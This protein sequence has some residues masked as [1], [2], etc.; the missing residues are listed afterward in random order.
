M[1]LEKEQIIKDAYDAFS[2]CKRPDHFTN[3]LH[4]DECNEHDQTM[5]SATL[6][7][8]DSKHLGCAGWAP[9]SFLTEEGFAY[10]MPRILELAITGK[11]N[12]HGELFLNDILFNLTPT[13]EYNRF[14]HYTIEQSRSVLNALRYAKDNFLDELMDY[15]AEGDLDNAIAYWQDAAT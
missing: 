2:E 15:A 12:A 14:K 6:E 10:Y 3:Y 11:D 13:D 8:L 1:K 9:F 4:C 5:R 7:T